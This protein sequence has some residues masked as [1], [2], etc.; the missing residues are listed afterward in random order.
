MLAAAVPPRAHWLRT[1]PFALLGCLWAGAPLAAEPASTVLR[2]QGSNTVGAR[3]APALVEGLFQQHGLREVRSLPGEREN[4]QR[5]TA[6]DAQGHLLQ[7]DIAAHGSSTGFTALQAGHAELAASSRP[8]KDSEVAAMAAFGDLRDAGAEQVIALDGLAIIVHPDN[9]LQQ[10]NTAD[11][12][13]LF[14]GELDNWQALGGADAPIRLY[15][16]DDQSGTYDTFKELVLA[17]NGKRLHADAQRFE[18]NTLLSAAVQ[19][20][21]QGIGFVGLDSV[22][23]A[24]A[25]AISAGEARALLPSENSVATEDYPLSRRLFLYGRPDAGNPWA[26][27]LIE[28]AHSAQGQQIVQ[29]V[30][31]VAQAVR[32]MQIAPDPRMPQGYRQLA[33]QAQRLSVNFRF[34]EGS[35]QLDNKALRDIQRVAAYLDAHGKLQHS[36][37]LVGFGD[38]KHDAQRAELLSRLRAM[39][40]RRELA[41]NGVIV[42]DLVGYGD[43]LPVATNSAE[44]GRIRN[45]RVEV[46]LH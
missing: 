45:R 6:R 40:V 22:G 14:S 36:A 27:R 15:A 20:D 4:E 46:W 34:Q 44:N 16:R 8:V 33:A 2:I 1:L 25:L 23:Q 10:L 17:A 37:T 5:V 32:A 11:L 26:Q 19:A 39:A 3:L 29:R 31:F 43:E 38:A 24:K 41:R 18:S 12:A 9:P 13:K 28:F 21:R 42:R 35:A 30:G 7:V